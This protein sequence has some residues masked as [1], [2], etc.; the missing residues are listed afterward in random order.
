MRKAI[1]SVAS[2]LVLLLG[3]GI[4]PNWN[5]TMDVPTERLNFRGKRVVVSNF[6]QAQSAVSVTSSVQIQQIL[7][8]AQ[9][10]DISLL[11][12]NELKREGIPAEAMV[13]FKATQLKPDQVWLR[14]AIVST[15]L[16]K[17]GTAHK[18]TFLLTGMVFGGIL[19]SPFY[20]Y[21]GADITYRAEFIDHTGKILLQT[22]DRKAQG[23]YKNRYIWPS[24][25]KSQQEK[26]T[27]M[28]PEVFV[29]AVKKFFK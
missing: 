19:P 17:S 2:L 28:T 7:E 29:D 8:T 26:I 25:D 1:L 16:R 5:P 12:A 23:Y 20:G 3:C 10:Q 15:S 11:I 14:G 9:V 4:G 24:L 18:I 27:T 22:G 21:S 13:E 6:L